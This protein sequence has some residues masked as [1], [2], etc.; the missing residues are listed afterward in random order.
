MLEP[1]LKSAFQE[2]LF[3]G[4]YSLLLG[5]GVSL[6]SRNRF[7]E[8]LRSAERLRKDL[9]AQT[10]ARE[11]TSLQRVYSLLSDGQVKSEIIDIFSGC[12]PGPTLA[13]LPHFTWKTIFTFNVDD[14]LEEVYAS[15]RTSKQRLCSLNFDSPFESSND[16]ADLIAVHLHGYV[17][18]PE[19]GFVFSA[20]EYA[21]VMRELNPWTHVLAETLATE[22][23][24][25]AGTSLN[26]IDLEFYLSHRSEETPRR[27]R[28]PSLLIEPCPDVTTHSDCR[29]YGLTLVQAEFD[30]FLEWLRSAF[31]A[32]PTLADLIV[33]DVGTIFPASVTQRELLRYFTDFEIVT[34][35][36]LPLPKAP[37]PFLY[38]REPEWHDIHTHIDIERT[39]NGALVDLARSAL[40]SHPTAKVLLLLDAPGTGK[41]TMLKRVATDLVAT[42][43]V[44]FNVRTLSR[45]DSENAISCLRQAEVDQIFLIVDDFAEH[46]DQLKL[47]VEEASLSDKIRVI[48]A[49]RDY[50]SDHIALFLDEEDCIRR[51]LLPLTRQEL[52]QLI[53]RYQEFGLIG[54]EDA[55]R[56]PQAFAARLAKDFVTIAVCRI[57]NDFKPLDGIVESL[58]EASTP[59]DRQIYICVALARYCHIGGVRY[60]ILQRIAGF[61]SSI[62]LMINA[63]SALPLATH[64]EDDD[65]IV[66][67][68]SIIADRVLF[69]CA[70]RN[71]ALLQNTFKLLA[72]AI[73]PHVNREAI[74]RRSPEARLAG[75]L[76]D[77]D[78]IVRPLIGEA[79]A[80]E[81]YVAAQAKWE[82]NSRYW[83]QRALL[84]A[85]R[86]IV[87]AIQYARHAIAIERHSFGFTTLG[88]LLLKRM[89]MQ[90]QDK[91]ETFSDAF[92]NLRS[93][94]E[95]ETRI[96]RITIHPITV[97]INGTIRFLELGGRLK[98]QQLDFIK[99]VISDTSYRFRKDRILQ[100]RIEILYKLL[101]L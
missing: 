45:V 15:A 9:C 36:E 41:S 85:E 32:P 59:T 46:V 37:A 16:K 74:K 54:N 98:P 72:D 92:T 33:P 88:L 76:F 64:P 56:N 71:P 19:S 60:S 7:G 95:R 81:F 94:I 63:L 6:D 3:R 77:G 38:G 1:S 27:G 90:A 8:K 12:T 52:L 44:A 86:N 83:Q 70:K 66:P 50:R 49:E 31:P 68:N 55:A 2:S 51:P 58:W 21:R 13:N 25:I 4:R 34:S 40:F 61:R 87:A 84:E 23:F 82:W 28:G 35:A 48:G 91:E 20:T 53:H 93:A 17:R 47:I 67:M 97:L 89:D 73:A 80:E 69:Y 11:S 42:G 75:R 22:P 65:Y 30:K 14:V 18:K 62:A 57:L 43:S 24:I 26:E 100:S 101:T 99:G 5:S 96:S 39:D 78:K 10:G 79:A 29:R